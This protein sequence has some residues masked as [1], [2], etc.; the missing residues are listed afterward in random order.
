MSS[1]LKCL[2]RSSFRLWPSTSTITSGIIPPRYLTFGL[3]LFGNHPELLQ[4]AQRVEVSLKKIWADGNWRS[5]SGVVVRIPK[6][7]LSCPTAG[8]SGHDPHCMIH[9]C[10]LEEGPV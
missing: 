1:R 8:F 3:L 7:S 4:H 5:S 9:M 6:A 10:G 2:G